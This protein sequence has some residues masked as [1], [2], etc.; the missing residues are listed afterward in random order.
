MYNQGE[1]QNYIVFIYISIST[2]LP[3]SRELSA[4]NDG[5]VGYENKDFKWF[6]LSFLSSFLKER[7][8]DDF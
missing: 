2:F 5:M 6:L 3:F 1:G 4:D 7:F 8:L